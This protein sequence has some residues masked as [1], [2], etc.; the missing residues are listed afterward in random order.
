MLVALVPGTVLPW[1]GWASF[2]WG[3]Q[4]HQEDNQLY[5][6][7]GVVVGTLLLVLGFV[8]LTTT[9]VVMPVYLWRERKR[10]PSDSGS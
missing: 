5:Y 2:Q 1:T 8:V 4:R 7:V 3:L 10:H 6:A 9:V